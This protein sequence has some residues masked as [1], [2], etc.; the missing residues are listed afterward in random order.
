MSAAVAPVTP[1]RGRGRSVPRRAIEGRLQELFP[2]LTRSQANKIARR[3]RTLEG[4]VSAAQ[5][6]QRG[7]RNGIPG[8]AYRG[9]EATPNTALRLMGG[10]AS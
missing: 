5:A 6:H 8:G 10:A 1:G 9:R 7:F 3:N 2:N 4:A